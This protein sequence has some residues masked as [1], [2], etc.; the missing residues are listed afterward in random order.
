MSTLWPKVAAL[1]A[2][3][4][5]LVGAAAILLG[6]VSNEGAAQQQAV[7]A[8]AALAQSEKLRA[9]EAQHA[10]DVASAVADGN[11]KLAV[12]AAAGGALS[13]TIDRLRKYT[14]RACSVPSPAASS[15]A[16]APAPAAVLVPPE[17]PASAGEL[18]RWVDESAIAA[19]VAKAVTP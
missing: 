4:I 2:L 13:S 12:V 18:A 15:A 7:D 6:R 3:L 5:A 16:S 11:A 14:P 17:L 10:E 8:K 1:L 19:G 9:E